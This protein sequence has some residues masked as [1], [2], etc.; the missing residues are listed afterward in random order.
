LDADVGRFGR[1]VGV[2]LLLHGAFLLAAYLAA[3]ALSRLFAHPEQGP[4]LQVVRFRLNEIT[5][6]VSEASRVDEPPE[7]G[8]LGRFHSRSQDLVPGDAD[9]PVPAGGV[10]ATEN[11]IPG[12]AAEEESAGGDA[13]R[14]A[15]TRRALSPAGIQPGVRDA[16]P[17]S[18]EGMLTGRRTRSGSPGVGARRAHEFADAGALAFGEYAFSTRAWDYEPY[19]HHMRRKLY[20]AWNPPAAYRI[21]GILDGGWTLVR[22]VIERDGTVS[23]AQILDTQ[24]HESLH[25]S[26]FAAMRGAAPFRPL[27]ADFPEENLVVTVRFVYMPPGVPPQ[28]VP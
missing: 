16:L 7:T 13:L 19:W 3:P 25:R 14:G 27:P 4:R 12:N 21:Y 5:A 20:A 23:S 6:D 24:G 28:D 15:A 11:S 26:S 9:A 1:S 22:A 10:L 2:S 17:S 8:F 18:V